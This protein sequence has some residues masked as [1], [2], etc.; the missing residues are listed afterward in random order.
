MLGKYICAVVM[1]EH[2]LPRVVSHSYVREKGYRSGIG[3][4]PMSPAGEYAGMPHFFV[5]G[6][7]ASYAVEF[8]RG[9]DDI[10]A[11]I[12]E[13]MR[14]KSIP[15][16]LEG[17]KERLSPSDPKSYA[18]GDIFTPTPPESV[19]PYQ[20]Q[21][22]ATQPPLPGFLVPR[23]PV[24]VPEKRK[25]RIRSQGSSGSGRRNYPSVSVA[26]GAQWPGWPGL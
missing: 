19:S 22:P 17:I 20:Q 21:I 9:I 11:I 26:R 18:T 4:V 25:I 16:T 5:V 23:H 3:G 15:V 14:S 1:D 10:V 24:S 7:N 13:T 12:A 6:N 2:G 8:K